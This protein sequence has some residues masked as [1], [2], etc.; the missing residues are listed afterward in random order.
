VVCIAVVNYLIDLIVLLAE[1]FV[2]NSWLFITA[3]VSV[4]LMCLSQM[5]EQ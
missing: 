3:S 1:P 4:K 2:I 5:S